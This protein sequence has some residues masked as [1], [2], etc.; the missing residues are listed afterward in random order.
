MPKQPTSPPI[1]VQSVDDNRIQPTE[2]LLRLIPLAHYPIDPNTGERFV[3]SVEFNISRKGVCVLR[4]G[5]AEEV[6]RQF[7]PDFGIAELSAYE[8]RK[9]GCVIAI[10]TDPEFT[11][12]PEDSHAVIYKQSD[13]QPKANLKDKQVD[14]LTFLA[15]KG[16]TKKPKIP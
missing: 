10:E 6:I 5:M 4:K 1:P 16:L 9:A 13:K 14:A 12:W 3:S 11:H 8:I 15:N 2:I 7:F